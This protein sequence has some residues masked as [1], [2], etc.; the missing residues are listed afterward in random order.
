M[1]PLE[2]VEAERHFRH[3][4]ENHDDLNR[5]DNSCEGRGDRGL[6]D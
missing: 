1:S 6:M 5:R 4:D 2:E 3:R